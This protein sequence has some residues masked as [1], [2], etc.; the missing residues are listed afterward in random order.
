MNHTTSGR[1]A[2]CG[3]SAGLMLAV[4]LLGNVLPMA[5][6][7][8]PAAAGMFLIP[9]ARE[10]GPRTGL[11]LYLAVAVL[12]LILCSDKEA[13]FFFL[14]LLG[15][16][17]VVRT[18]LQHIQKRPPRV[19]LK[20]VL[21]NAAIC[22]IYAILLF[23]LTIPDLQAAFSSRTPLLLIVFLVLGNM[24][25]LVYDLCLARISDLYFYRLRPKLFHRHNV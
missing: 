17:P 25:F 21:F 12:S 9:A 5:T 18:K 20:L 6:F 1:V 4:M 3:V 11:L 13:A 23:V 19:A 16:Y 8:C 14:F 15:W 7:V 24:T 22:L 2:F 10:Y